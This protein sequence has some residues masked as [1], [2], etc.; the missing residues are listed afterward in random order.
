[1]LRFFQIISIVLITHGLS[2]QELLVPIS[3]NPFLFQYQ[4]KHISAARQQPLELPFA[5]D[6]NQLSFYPN[7]LKWTDRDVFVNNNF[8]VLPPSIGVATFDALDESGKP[9]SEDQRSFGAADHLTSQPINLSGVTLADQVY[10]SF[11]W[12]AGGLGEKPEVNRDYF[13]IEFLSNGIE[14]EEVLRIEAPNHVNDFEQVFIQVDES[15]LHGQ[16]QFRF[17][18]YGNLAG[19]VDSWNVDYVLLDKNRNPEFESSVS[20]VAYVKGNGKFFKSYYQM[21]FRHFNQEML[22]DT[23]SVRVKNNFLNTV[24]IVDNYTVTNLSDGQVIKAYNGPSTDIVSLQDV[25]YFYPEFD[26]GN[27]VPASDTTIIEVK[28]YFES[29]AENASPD[30]VRANNKMVEQIVFGNTFAYD[31]GTAERAYRMVN[32]DYGKVA[33]KFDV[34]TRDTLRAV[35]IYFPDFP[36][37]TS[38]SKD[39]FFNIAIYSSLDTLTGEDDEVIYRE[40]L[41]QKSDF[42]IPENEVFNGFAYYKFKPDF[43]EGLDYIIVE[44]EFYVAIEYEKNNDVDLGFD[45]NNPSQEYMYYNIGEGWY[46]TQYEGAIMINAIMGGEIDDFPTSIRSQSVPLVKVYPNPTI[47]QLYIEA[48]NNGMYGYKIFNIAGTLVKSEVSSNR[49][50]IDVSGL[51]PGI[52]ILIIEDGDNQLIGQAKFVKY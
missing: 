39:P 49:P 50:S 11:Y 2:A 9:Y 33:V 37:M 44:D 45:L 47:D 10:L 18:A 6:F 35:K 48:G 27:V 3:N 20:D 15:F 21:P 28:Y 34:S 26:L 25:D 38:S 1:M 4:N 5:D 22:K 8:P 17:V 19:S 42:Y 29:S 12:Q 23:F 32:Y 36:N 14:W 40:T 41:V 24:D 30:F 46:N 43:N 51:Q 16:F 7:S 52:F 31:D 13:V